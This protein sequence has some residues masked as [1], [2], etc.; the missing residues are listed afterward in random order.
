MHT[1]FSI[2]H[3]A[4]SVGRIQNQQIVF[5]LLIVFKQDMS[6]EISENL[7]TDLR[8]QLNR[9]RVDRLHVNHPVFPRSICFLFRLSRTP[10]VREV[11]TLIF[12]VFVF[13]Y[14]CVRE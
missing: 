2:Q 11:N 13:L 12:L 9:F 8:V 1:A 4:F 5:K 10:V 14:P 3:P 7:G 6:L